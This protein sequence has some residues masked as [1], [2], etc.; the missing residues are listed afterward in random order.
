M[1]F[2]K[3]LI[4]TESESV[5]YL[6]PIPVFQK[7]YENDPLNDRVYKLGYETL[8]ERQ[9]LMGQELP[10]QYDSE[11]QENRRLAQSSY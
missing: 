4:P 2:E 3:P 9:K 11:R 10:G 8:D 6:A 7:M 5:F 1:Y